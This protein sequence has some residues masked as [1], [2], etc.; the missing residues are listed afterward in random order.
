MAVVVFFF[1]KPVKPFSV[2]RI[3][4]LNEQGGTSVLRPKGGRQGLK[5]INLWAPN[6]ENVFLDVRYAQC[7]LRREQAG[8]VRL[9][10]WGEKRDQVLHRTP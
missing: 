4:D 3:K 5:D 8:G 1:A 2:S 6:A 9:E 10:D 7:P